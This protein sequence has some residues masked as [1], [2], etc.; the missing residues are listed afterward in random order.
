VSSAYRFCPY[1][2][3]PLEWLVGQPHPACAAC[4]RTFFQNSK[5]CVGTIVTD[6]DAV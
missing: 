6:G 1:C 4:G 2:G 5:P 3:G